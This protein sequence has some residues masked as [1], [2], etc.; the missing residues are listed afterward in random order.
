[1]SEMSENIVPEV[2]EKNASQ[3]ESQTLVQSE[4][5]SAS[6]MPETAKKQPLCWVAGGMLWW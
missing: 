1:M 3:S 5:Q 2:A 6:Q 4:P